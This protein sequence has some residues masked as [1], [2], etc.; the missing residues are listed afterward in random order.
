[1]YNLYVIGE[2]Q[3]RVQSFAKG[4]GG[5]TGVPAKIFV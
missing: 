1:M 4:G 5:P 3:E 2:I